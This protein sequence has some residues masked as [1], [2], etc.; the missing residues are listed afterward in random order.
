MLSNNDKWNALVKCDEKYDGKF[1][2]G[3]K[4]TGIFCRPSCKSKEPLKQNVEFYDNADEA[5]RN[6]FRPCKRCRPDLIEYRPVLDMVERA[7]RVFNLYYDDKN[8]LKLEINALGISQNRLIR[9][10]RE[11]YNMTPVEYLN[12]LRVERAAKLLQ[13]SDADILTIAMKCGFGS[14]SS[15][16]CLFKHHQGATPGEYRKTGG[17]L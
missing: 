12:K 15:F 14:I 7:E 2:Y 1:F 9:L 3:V 11:Q 17:K 10:F 4:T 16:Y 8:K 6:G 5:V 13:D